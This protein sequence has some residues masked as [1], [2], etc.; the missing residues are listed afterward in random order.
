MYFKVSTGI[1][2]TPKTAAALKN[3]LGYPRVE[4]ITKQL[5]MS[6]SASPRPPF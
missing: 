2:I 4:N 6:F 1:I 5:D 3:K